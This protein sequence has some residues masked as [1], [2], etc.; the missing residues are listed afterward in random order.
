M[1]PTYQYKAIDIR[2]ILL[3]ETNN[4]GIH[5]NYS[6]I[7]LFN[8]GFK[9]INILFKNQIADADSSQPTDIVEEEGQCRIK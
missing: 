4:I 1:Y 2:M 7:V 9:E 8:K 6:T 3:N 5:S